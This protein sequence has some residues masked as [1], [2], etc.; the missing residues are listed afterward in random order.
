VRASVVATLGRRI[1]QVR[2]VKL[3]AHAAPSK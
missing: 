3:P 2:L 1:K